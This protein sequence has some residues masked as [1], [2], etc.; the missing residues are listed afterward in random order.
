M[1]QLQVLPPEEDYS[2]EPLFAEQE[3]QW[4]MK[5]FKPK[6]KQ[7]CALLAQGMKNKEVAALVGCTPHYITMLLRQPMIKAEIQRIS[8]VTGARLELMFTKVVDAIG[9]TLENGNASEKLKA[10]RLHGELT[11]RIGRK[12]PF[13][14]NLNLND[15]RLNNLANKLEHLLDTKKAG[16]YDERGAPIFEDAEVVRTRTFSGSA[17]AAE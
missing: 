2:D 5:F 11:N 17:E 8:E 16:L 1:N 13:A 12:D 3:T 15:D 4:E 14:V 7:I 10:G 6:H 9:D